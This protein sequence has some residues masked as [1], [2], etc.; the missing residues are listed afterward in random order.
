VANTIVQN[1]RK[2]GTAQHHA[3]FVAETTRKITKDV[4]AIKISTDVEILTET[5]NCI[6]QQ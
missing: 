3:P 1:A 5:P 4:N 2:V 6:N